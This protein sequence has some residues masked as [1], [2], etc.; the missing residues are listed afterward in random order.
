[1]REFEHSVVPKDTNR[2]QLNFLL[3]ENYNRQPIQK[4]K[5]AFSFIRM[6]PTL[7][8]FTYVGLV[9][10]LIFVFFI[11][12]KRFIGIILT[13]ILTCYQHFPVVDEQFLVFRY[14]DNHFDFLVSQS[15]FCRE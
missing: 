14:L 10:I 11:R 1:M 5:A 8:Y 13:G 4:A 15:V 6:P 3:L 9:L 2:F 12:N 7:L